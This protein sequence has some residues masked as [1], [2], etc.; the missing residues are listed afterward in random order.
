M[1]TELAALAAAGA[2]TLVQQ[3]ATDGWGSVRRR[4][5]GFLARRRGSTDE[6]AVEGELE[7][8]RADLVA[9]QEAGNRA[10]A[11]VVEA[12]W[13]MRLQ[14][15]LREDPAAAAELRRLLDEVAPAERPTTI[16]EVHNTLNGGAHN[17]AV[18]QAGAINGGVHHWR[19]PPPDRP[20]AG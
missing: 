6:A 20:Q 10:D 9:A 17:S 11:E 3:M 15:L 7:D 2:T 14:R 13:R 19:T 8:S 16:R 4:M 12:S 1:D 5:A 18:I